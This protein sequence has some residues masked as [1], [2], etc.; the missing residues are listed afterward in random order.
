MPHAPAAHHQSGRR[1]RLAR[2]G[3]RPLPRGLRGGLSAN[4]RADRPGGARV[5]RAE[6]RAAPSSSSAGRCRT[7]I[8]SR[9]RSSS[10][11]C[12]W[13]T[14]ESVKYLDVERCRPDALGIG[15]PGRRRASPRGSCRRTAPRG[16]RR[17]LSGRTRCARYIGGYACGVSVN[18]GTDVFT[19]SGLRTIAND[20]IVRSR[21]PAARCPPALQ[22]GRTTSS[23]RPP[24]RLSSFR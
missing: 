19:H 24:A 23:S 6:D 7:T 14:V 4:V 8:A 13:S 21:T 9:A 17:A 2:G 3:D 20:Q 16:R 22:P 18:A 12:R 10:R 5:G 11:A 1:A 15:L